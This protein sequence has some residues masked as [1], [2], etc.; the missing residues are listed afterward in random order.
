[1]LQGQKSGARRQVSDSGVRGVADRL[2]YNGWH[3]RKDRK[4]H[5]N[6]YRPDACLAQ[7]RRLDLTDWCH[8]NASGWP[9]RPEQGWRFEL[10][11][12]PATGGSSEHKWRTGRSVPPAATGRRLFSPEGRRS[13]GVEDERQRDANGT[14]STDSAEGAVV[15]RRGTGL[16][17]ADAKSV[18]DRDHG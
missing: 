15:T 11:S 16:V 7:Q 2:E 12:R 17:A 5:A 10:R 14:N 4:R 1:M 18:S 6:R 9:T 13:K 3:T 8:Q